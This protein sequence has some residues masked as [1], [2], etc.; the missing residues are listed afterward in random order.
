MFESSADRIGMIIRPALIRPV[1]SGTWPVDRFR[2]PS[3]ARQEVDNVDRDRGRPRGRRRASPA[4]R[5]AGSSDAWPSVVRR[6]GTWHRRSLGSSSSLH[7]RSGRRKPSVEPVEAR[8]RSSSHSVSSAL[9]RASASSWPTTRP[10]DRSPV[11]V[12]D[13]GCG[14]SRRRASAPRRSGRGSPVR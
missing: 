13:L 1:A 11:D 8:S 12:H 7:Q 5:A 10:S 2:A 14:G 6:G 9:F 3:G 4:P